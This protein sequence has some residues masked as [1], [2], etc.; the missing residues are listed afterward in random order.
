MFSKALQT[1]V[2]RKPTRNFFRPCLEALESRTVLSVILPASKGCERPNLLSNG[3]GKRA[4]TTT[5]HRSA[6]CKPR[7]E[8]LEDRVV[9][10]LVFGG[11]DTS[12]SDSYSMPSGSLFSDLR[13]DIASTFPGSTFTSS[14]TLTSNYLNTIQVLL[15][16]TGGDRGNGITVTT[17]LT[18]SEQTAL[19]DFV[20]RGGG[21]II[22]VDNDSFGG[23]SVNTDAVNQ[24]FISPFGLHVTGK[25]SGNPAPANV[26]NANHPVTNGPFGRVST[27][28]TADPGWFDDLGPTSV[29]LAEL[30][31]NNGIA[32]T[33]INPGALSANSGGVVFLS[34][35]NVLDNNRLP[36]FDNR[37][38][39]RNAIAFVSPS[40]ADITPTR[41]E[42]NTAQGGVDLGYK[43][44]GAALT[45][46]T[47]AALY[48]SPTRTFD[49]QTATLAYE[50]Q[51]NQPADE[52][53]GDHGP[54][55]VSASA[56]GPPVQGAQYLLLVTDPENVLGNFDSNKDVMALTALPDIVMSGSED[57][58]IPIHHLLSNI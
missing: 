33:A 15:I 27:I 10:S 18:S 28:A 34:D 23:A 14:L 5:R 8:I 2:A 11:F 30:A 39:I 29:G 45:Q 13:S 22:L 40:L 3:S 41:F 37:T 52:A 19:T 46:D 36:L 26:T 16:N 57:E 38:M 56:L 35:F 20:E 49:P 31:A 6:S 51:I 43:V 47:T 44:S 55:N 53:Q 50:K 9:P 42:W 1:K 54:F 12:R 17:P 4:R 7:L 24:S 25:L 32:L 58:V 48:W 21:A